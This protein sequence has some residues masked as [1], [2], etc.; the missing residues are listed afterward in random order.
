M[1]SRTQLLANLLRYSH[2]LEETIANLR[3]FPWDSEVALIVLSRN[4]VVELLERYLL[5]NLAN[6]DVE[7]WANAIEG[8]EDINY[9]SGHENILQEIIHILANPVLTEPLDHL[10][11][12]RLIKKLRD[13]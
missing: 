9:E 6:C 10:L 1:Q 2:P 4:H 7:A 8:R 5:G 11:A 12:E 3:Q 13:I